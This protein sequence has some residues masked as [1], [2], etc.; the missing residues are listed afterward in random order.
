MRGHSATRGETRR[1]RPN[2]PGY[3]PKT[4]NEFVRDENRVRSGSTRERGQQVASSQ[5]AGD[6]KPTELGWKHEKLERQQQSAED[7]PADTGRWEEEDNPSS[8]V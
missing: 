4:E 8:D 3:F 2:K 1:G 6:A 5:V 7:T